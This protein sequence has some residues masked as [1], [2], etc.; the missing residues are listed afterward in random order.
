MSSLDISLLFVALVFLRK[1]VFLHNRWLEWYRIRFRTLGDVLRGIKSADINHRKLNRGLKNAL[2]SFGRFFVI[3][4]NVK[5][6]DIKHPVL[7]EDNGYTDIGHVSTAV[8]KAGESFINPDITVLT[9]K[10]REHYFAN[11][12]PGPDW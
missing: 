1:P 10:A 11:M 5:E 4:V 3:L 2:K 7:V 8:R 9:F 6:E 12:F